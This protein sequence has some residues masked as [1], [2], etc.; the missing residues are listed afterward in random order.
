MRSVLS[1]GFVALCLSGC[2]LGGVEDGGDFLPVIA[3]C[4]EPRAEDPFDLRIGSFDSWI[5]PFAEGEVLTV[6]NGFQGGEHVNL[7][8][9]ARIEV[10]RGLNIRAMVG[11]TEVASVGRQLTPCPDGRLVLLENLAL[12]LLIEGN[13]ENV[14]L[15]AELRD[16]SGAPVTSTTAVVNFTGS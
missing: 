1:L 12:V 8:A 13:W 4:L 9:A 11:R 15:E 14:V 7:S 10:E 6:V 3:S 2:L 16:V 5:Q